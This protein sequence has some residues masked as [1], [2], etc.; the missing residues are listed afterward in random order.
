MYTQ[1]L[2]PLDGSETA[3]KILP[4]A[5][6]LARNL[7]I[8]VELLAVV[9]IGRYASGERARYLGTLIDTAIRRNQEYL[10]RVAKHFRVT[11]QNGRSRE[12]CLRRPSLRRPPRTREP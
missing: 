6:A 9:E 8:S 4:Y 12:V 11:V 7:K 3:E 10:Q 2:V 5:R 1:M